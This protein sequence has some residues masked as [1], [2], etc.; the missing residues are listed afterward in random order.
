MDSLPAPW[1]TLDREHKREALQS[2]GERILH[3]I[4]RLAVVLPTGLV[5]LALLAR[6][7]PAHPARLLRTR[8]DWIDAFLQ[9][10]GAEFSTSLTHR[11]PAIREALAR[12]MSEGLV[13]RIDTAEDAVYR[14]VGSR[15]ITLEYYKNQ[16]LHFFV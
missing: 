8:V 13:E 4:D 7:A 5:A 12:F 16:L 14:V 2:L 3:R 9:R 1:E 11:E 15:R 6:A 10:E